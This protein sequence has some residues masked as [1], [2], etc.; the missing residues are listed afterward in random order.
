MTRTYEQSIELLTDFIEK[1]NN[2]VVLTGAGVSTESGL[3]DFRGTNGMWNNKHIMD[4][5]CPQ[6]MDKD[7]DTFLQFYRTRISDVIE[8]NP[9]S[10]H[11]ILAEWQSKGIVNTIITQNVDGY[12]RKASKGVSTI[13]EL[14]GDI[15]WCHCSRCNHEIPSMSFLEDPLCPVCKARMRPSIVMFGERLD[16]NAIANSVYK[17]INADLVIVLGSSLGVAPAN[18]L[19]MLV[20]ENGGKIAIVNKGETILDDDADLLIGDNSIGKVITD[21]NERLGH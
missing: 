9:N 6:G 5:A 12:H 19:P 8:C 15:N 2:A 14:H 7:Y 4:I 3:K 10:T 20:K 1:A 21:V 11:H 16:D 17:C 18:Q 13:I